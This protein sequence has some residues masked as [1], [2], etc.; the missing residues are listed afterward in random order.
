MFHF[1][2]LRYILTTG[3]QLQDRGKFRFLLPNQE[4]LFDFTNYSFIAEQKSNVPWLTLELGRPSSSNDNFI[5]IN[6]I[7]KL[8]WPVSACVPLLY[9]W[10]SHH[11]T[12]FL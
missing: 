10:Y 7:I 5:K 8:H 1:F 6:Q 3:I 4:Q 12:E 2:F 9:R 11:P